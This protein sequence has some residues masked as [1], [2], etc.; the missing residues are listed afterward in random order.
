MN[1]EL[2]YII[3]N[4]IKESIDNVCFLNESQESKS[5]SAAKKIVK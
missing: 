5:I 1:K 4:I 3:K 2:E